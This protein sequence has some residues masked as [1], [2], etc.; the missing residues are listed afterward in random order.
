MCFGGDKTV[1]SCALFLRGSDHVLF[2]LL[3][4]SWCRGNL[5]GEPVHP[6]SFLRCAWLSLGLSPDHFSIPVAEKPQFV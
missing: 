3:A 6:P 5:D 2:S 1:L 4:T